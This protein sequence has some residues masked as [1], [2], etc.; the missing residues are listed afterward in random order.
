MS[1][2]SRYRRAVRLHTERR[3]AGDPIVFLH[4]MGASSATWSA[5]MDLLADRFT[6][7][8]GAWTKER[9]FP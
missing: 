7:A 8:D 1:R 6:L 4:G 3:G 2:R 5:V 9:L